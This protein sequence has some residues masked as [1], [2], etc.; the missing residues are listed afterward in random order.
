[1]GGKEGVTEA[2]L[3]YHKLKEQRGG[4]ALGVGSGERPWHRDQWNNKEE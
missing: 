4:I 2:G 1:M 3:T